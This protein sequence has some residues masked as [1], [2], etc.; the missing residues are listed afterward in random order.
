MLTAKL[1]SMRSVCRRGHNGCVLVRDKRIISTGYNGPP[2][3]D[4]HCT[5]DTCDIT[6]PCLRSIHAEANAVYFAA[7]HGVNLRGAQAYCTS[8]PC[9]KCAEALYASGISEVYYYQDYRSSEGLDFLGAHKVEVVKLD[10]VNL[11][12]AF[13]YDYLTSS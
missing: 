7:K 4:S 9:L 12:K 13:N 8:A 6:K 5:D 1:F 3:G 2:Q 10:K 11:D